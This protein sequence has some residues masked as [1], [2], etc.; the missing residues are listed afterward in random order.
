M[1]RVVV[2]S[3]TKIFVRWHGFFLDRDR[4]TDSQRQS[5]CERDFIVDCK[6]LVMI[7][8]TGFSK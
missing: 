7:Q 8:Y 1:L 3:N 4:Q 5:V 2:C 6:Y